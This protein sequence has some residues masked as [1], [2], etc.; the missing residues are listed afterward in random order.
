MRTRRHALSGE[1]AAPARRGATSP[2]WRRASGT[3]L[4]EGFTL[5]ETLLTVLIMAIVLA[6]AFPTVPLFFG[7]QTSIQN[8]FSAV[9]QLVIASETI[10][11]FVH[12]GVD[13]W[14]ATP[15]SPFVSA[16]ANA[17][18]FTSNTGNALGPQEVVIQVTNGV[19][20]TRTFGMSLIPA[21]VVSG[22]STCFSPT[23]NCAYSASH[24]DDTVL[25]NY[26]TNGTGGSPVF[27][28]YLQG[29][30]VCGGPPPGAPTTTTK[31][32]ALTSGHTYTSLTVNALTS[33]VAK[34]DTIFIGSGPNAQTV[35]ASAA[36]AVNAT[37]ISVSSFVASQAWPVGTSVYDSALTTVPGT[38][39][40]TL[41][42]AVTAGAGPA[43]LKVVALTTPVAQ[44]DTVVVGTGT[45]TQTFTA[46]GAAGVGATSIPVSAVTVNAPYAIGSSVYD[47]T[48]STS[49]PTTL[50]TALTAGSTPTTLKVA[51]LTTAVVSGDTILVGTGAPPRPSRRAARPRWGRRRSP[52][53]A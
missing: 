10:T 19:S 32:S 1:T 37:T 15:A 52:S 21:S 16:S 29:G 45:T 47:S 44:G 7:E 18:T 26:L 31:T 36:A 22:K 2:R 39:P 43:S 42:T 30:E 28:Y 53:P 25:I 11:R 6:V 38:V 48:C 4:Q 27:T 41:T 24:A 49:A 50:T 3:R 35:T 34:G 8:T 14:A 9:D 33:A 51:A 40:T 46:S 17:V 12:E 13:A 20:G 23:S 5:I